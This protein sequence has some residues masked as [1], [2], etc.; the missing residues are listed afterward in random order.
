MKS[1]I[2]LLATDSLIYGVGSALNGLAGFVLLPVLIKALSAQEYG[3]YALAEMF[4]NLFLVVVGMGQTTVF[5]GQYFGTPEDQRPRLVGGVLA[6]LLLLS[7]AL[8]LMFIAA[9]TLVGGR[10]A[11]ELP[12]QFYWLIAMIAVLEALWGVCATLLRIQNHRWRFI[13][14]SV[15]QFLGSLTTTII[16]ITFWRKREEAIL[17]GRLFA[18][19]LLILLLLPGVW[20][21]LFDINWRG[22]SRTAKLGLPLIPATLAT[23]WVAMSPRFF[24]EQFSDARAIGIYAMSTKVSGLAALFFVQPFAMAWTVLLFKVQ[25]Q[26]FP[27]RIYARIL[28]YY[29]VVGLTLALS[30]GIAAPYLVSLLR[31]EH[32]P[33]SD[34]VILL[35][36][37]ATI[38]SGLMYPVNVGIYLRNQTAQVL[39][40]FLTCAASILVVGS[41]LASRWGGEGAALSLLIVYLLQA[42]MLGRLNRR[43]Y[44]IS[45]EWTRIAKATAALLA[46][47]FLVRQIRLAHE[48]WSAGVM[49]L[50]FLLVAAGA[51]GLLRF[52]DVSEI[53]VLRNMIR[54]V[55]A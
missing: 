9:L 23:V 21:C 41:I 5:P 28:T 1:T 54:R 44:P 29:W 8:A 11:P 47:Y 12:R 14:V 17:Y 33:L 18:D 50:I 24:L 6:L 40:T 26:P 42:F 22:A 39:P 38:V 48:A 43:L 4:L 34:T 49:P 16:L 27:Q 2:T 3:R 46:A 13:T 53:G 55:A 7:M 30:I 37:L 51:L 32:F 52:F 19:L 25:H 35:T 31:G 10:L 20:S 36:A 15:V 45:W